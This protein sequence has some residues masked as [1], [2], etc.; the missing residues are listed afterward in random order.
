MSHHADRMK[1][2]MGRTLRKAWNQRVVPRSDIPFWLRVLAIYRYQTGLIY[3]GLNRRAA[4]VADL[5]VSLAA[6]AVS[7]QLWEAEVLHYCPHRNS[8]QVG[9][10]DVPYESWLAMDLEVLKRCN[11][12]VMAGDWHQSAGCRR[13]LAF[14]MALHMPVVYT[15][16]AAIALDRQFRSSMVEIPCVEM[17]L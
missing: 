6:L 2:N 3:L 10:T 12:L 15:V 9:T 5:L 1:L 16:D 4:A 8:P 11:Y 14:A 7:A 13:E 17:Q